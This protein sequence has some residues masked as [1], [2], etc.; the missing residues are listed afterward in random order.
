[1]KAARPA[2]DGSVRVSR[3]SAVVGVTGLALLS[4][5]P[6]TGIKVTYRRRKSP[7]GRALPLSPNS[8][9]LGQNDHSPPVRT[10][11]T[12]EA[13]GERNTSR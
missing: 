1:M 4:R 8:L 10:M 3:S 13:D 11:D 12:S 5:G 6:A 7:P 2:W 9:S